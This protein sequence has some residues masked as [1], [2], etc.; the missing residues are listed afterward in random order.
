MPWSVSLCAVPET[1]RR[2]AVGSSANILQLLEQV[3]TPIESEGVPT[4]TA[5]IADCGVFEEPEPETE[6]EQ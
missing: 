3:G 6:A 1:A 2:G 4:T 5:V